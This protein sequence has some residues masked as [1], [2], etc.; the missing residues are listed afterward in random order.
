VYADAA[1]STANPCAYLGDLFVHFLAP[2]SEESVLPFVA[3]LG[4]IAELSF[5][6][7]LLVKSVSLLPGPSERGAA[8][9]PLQP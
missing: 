6:A 4:A 2:A 7:W 1:T 5:M 3:A 9:Q 8:L